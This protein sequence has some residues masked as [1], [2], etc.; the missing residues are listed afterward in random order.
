MSSGWSPR[1][2]TSRSGRAE[3]IDAK[4]AEVVAVAE[5]YG[6][7]RM[8]KL[9]LPTLR[10]D[11]LPLGE[12]IDALR[13]VIESARPEI[14]YLVHGGDIHTDHF[15][16]FTATMSVLKPFYMQRH[17]VR[18]VLCYETLSSTEAAPPLHHRIFV[19]NVYADIT[20]FLDRK[21]EIMNLYATE[22]HPDPMP[23]GPRPSGH[24]PATAAR[25]SRSNTPRPSCSSAK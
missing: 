4:A 17:G 16:I 21:V 7:A 20:P 2:H 3:T 13:R 22:L 14:V 25:P 23:R 18:R 24:W 15:A 6:I 5:A 19:P 1:R 12:L 10:L 11:T 8:F 9:G